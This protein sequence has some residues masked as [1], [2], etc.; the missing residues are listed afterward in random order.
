MAD[1]GKVKGGNL[2]GGVPVG[3]DQ[4]HTTSGGLISPVEGLSNDAGVG[5][6]PK[7]GVYGAI[8]EGPSFP[9]SGKMPG[10]N[11]KAIG[12]FFGSKKPGGG[13]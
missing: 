12:A 6:P 13:K 11:G 7:P 2:D 10:G 9:G 3:G 4:F 8:A 1:K 5:K